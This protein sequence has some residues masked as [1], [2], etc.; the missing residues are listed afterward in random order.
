MVWLNYRTP[1]LYFK[2]CVY[3]EIKVRDYILWRGTRAEVS[4]RQ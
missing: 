4:E 1:P 2:V 3:V